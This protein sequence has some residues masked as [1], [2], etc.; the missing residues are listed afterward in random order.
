MKITAVRTFT[1]WVDWCNWLF[2]RIDTDEGVCG[3]GEG[4]LH[5]SIAAVDAAIHEIAPQLVGQDPA[6]PERHWHR[7]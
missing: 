2:V 7:L 6:G 3:W 4:S 5:G 1:H